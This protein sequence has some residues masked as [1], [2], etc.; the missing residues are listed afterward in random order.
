[1][2]GQRWLVACPASGGVIFP[3]DQTDWRSA[4]ITFSEPTPAPTPVP[5]KSPEEI[6]RLVGQ[7]WAEWAGSVT[8]RY[9]TDGL[10]AA[11]L[12]YGTHWTLT[13]P[14]GFLDFG[15]W[16]GAKDEIW[17]LSSQELGIQDYIINGD[18]AR[19]FMGS[20]DSASVA[21]YTACAPSGK[22]RNVREAPPGDITSCPNSGRIPEFLRSRRGV[23]IKF[24]PSRIIIQLRI[25]CLRNTSG[26]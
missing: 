22:K 20:D 4:G 26:P 25:R 23:L 11:V 21:V 16:A 12:P 18:L 17:K 24:V 3:A 19:S 6:N 10:G 9:V 15:S 8:L 7:C 2:V 14:G 1:M 5:S 13:G